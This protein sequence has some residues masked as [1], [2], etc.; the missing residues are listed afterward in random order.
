MHYWRYVIQC[1]AMVT[2]GFTF[3][4]APIPEENEV[5]SEG[6]GWKKIRKIVDPSQAKVQ[7]NVNGFVDPSLHEIVV[8]ESMTGLQEAPLPSVI[9]T[10]LE[11]DLP[12]GFQGA[13][14]GVESDNEQEILF[15]DLDVAMAIQNGTAQDLYADYIIDDNDAT[16]MGGPGVQFLSC[17]TNWRHREFSGFNKS[18]SE[19]YQ[20]NRNSSYLNI[21]T[22]LAIQGQASVKIGY[23]YKKTSFCLPWAA[24]LTY[25]RIRGELT[26]NNTQFSSDF[27]VQT[28]I[29][30]T[31][32]NHVSYLFAKG[33]TFF[34]GPVPVHVGLAMPWGIGFD[35]GAQVGASASFNL[36]INGGFWLDYKCSFTSGCQPTDP[37]QGGTGTT[38][39]YGNGS[40]TISWD[41][42]DAGA[43]AEGKIQVRPYIYTELL[44]YMYLPEVASLSIGSELGLPLDVGALFGS[45]GNADGRNGQEVIGTTYL[46]GS[47]EIA[48]YW[49]YRLFLQDQVRSPINWPFGNIGD[50]WRKYQVNAENDI[51]RGSDTFK[52]LRRHIYFDAFNT[53][54]SAFQPMIVGENDVVVGQRE[55]YEVQNRP[56]YPFQQASTYRI[57]YGTGGQEIVSDSSEGSETGNIT[58]PFEFSQFWAGAG[59]RVISVERISDSLGRDFESALSHSDVSTQFTVEVDSAVPPTSP[60]EFRVTQTPR[61]GS[62]FWVCDFPIS[63]YL[64][65]PN[66]DYYQTQ[67]IHF[68]GD[69]VWRDFDVR[70]EGSRVVERYVRVPSSREGRHKVRIRACNS[71]GCS[72]WMTSNNFDVP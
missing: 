10:M 41:S 68:D 60:M 15:V 3:A 4:S 46:D 5:I 71:Y 59:E 50:T 22:N 58:A 30:E 26:F 32:R 27:E 65:S 62:C 51:V 18:F 24:T 52:T 56:C 45:C 29:S 16:P 64:T 36:P 37:E 67:I 13:T 2:I 20:H 42:L 49:G 21:N 8:I 39:T 55:D 25:A 66:A 11:E 1:L 53:T 12:E 28:A 34:I 19:S 47:A 31:W 43:L 54:H 17:S 48:L 69:N 35:L 7:T 40:D 23:K 63:N 61:G 70:V 9:R 44:A 38:L 72:S 57:T 6:N 14:N 33:E